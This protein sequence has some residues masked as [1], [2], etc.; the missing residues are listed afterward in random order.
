MQALASAAAA[1]N[2]V[3]NAARV[4][5]AASMGVGAVVSSEDDSSKSTPT[6]LPEEASSE[7]FFFEELELKRHAREKQ[8]P[9]ERSSSWNKAP[10]QKSPQNAQHHV[11]EHTWDLLF[12]SLRELRKEEEHYQRYT[13]AKQKVSAC[14]PRIHNIKKTHGPPRRFSRSSCLSRRNRRRCT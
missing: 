12:G 13:E 7:K 2:V 3:E 8:N 10:E 14:T 5:R 1:T 4:K 9:R 6:P 11:D